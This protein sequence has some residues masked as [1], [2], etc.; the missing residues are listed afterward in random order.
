M[1]KICKPRLLSH[2]VITISFILLFMFSFYPAQTGEPV[3]TN[4]S[5]KL[6]SG[7]INHFKVTKP[8]EELAKK[9]NL[10]GFYKKY[11]DAGGLPV[12]SSEKVSDYALMEAAWII[13]NM[14]GHRRD[15]IEAIA[16]EGVRVVVM[17]ADE[18]TTD[19]PE[20]SDLKPKEYWD[21]RARGLGATRKRPAV[22]CGEENLLSYPGDP[23]AAE[24]IL[25]HEFGHVIHEIGLRKVDPTFEKRLT[26]AY[27]S[28][29]S[30]GL[31]TNT[32]AATN[33][34]EYWAEGVQSWFDCN[35]ENDSVHNY[36]NTREEL[37]EYD[38]ELAGLLKEVFGDRDWR[39]K[40]PQKRK[41]TTPHLKDYDFSSGKVFRWRTAAQTR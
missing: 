25:I 27:R 8:P 5:S 17:A 16:G 2:R 30:K 37:K 7:T 18:Y 22:S 4:S 34:S 21:R 23:Y 24:N 11:C 29:I 39:Y 3:N 19:I 1:S 28:A 40:K 35:R 26:E 33:P 14:I 32:Y 13:T 31:W 20:H 10:S 41:D 9:L 15:I 36:V 12:V 6:D 38:P